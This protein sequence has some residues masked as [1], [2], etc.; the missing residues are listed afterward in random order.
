MGRFVQIWTILRGVAVSGPGWSVG[1]PR[2]AVGLGGSVDLPVP[3]G[4]PR[5]ASVLAS[6]GGPRSVGDFDDVDGEGDEGPIGWLD[7]IRGEIARPAFELS[8]CAQALSV[9]WLR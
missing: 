7:G 9:R 1:G 6:V 2:W 4:G 8:T 5:W 3:V